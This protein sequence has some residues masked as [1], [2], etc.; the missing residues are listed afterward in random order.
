MLVEAGHCGWAGVSGR[1]GGFAS[2]SLTHGF[3]NGQE[4]WPDELGRAGPPRRREPRRHRRH[5]AT[6]RHRLPLGA[7]RRALR[8][9][10]AAPARRARGHAA[11]LA[12]A[13]PRRAAARPRT[14]CAPRSTR[15]R[16][17][18]GCGTAT[19]RRWSTRRGWPGGCGTPAS[20]LGV[21]VYE[22]TAATGRRR[23]TPAALHVRT[24][25]RATV[26][27]RPGRARHQRLP[28]AAAPAAADA[29]PVYDYVLMTEPLTAGAAGA[30]R[31]AHR[32]GLGDAAT[33]STTT[34]SPPTTGSCGA[35]T[36]RSTT[37]A[38][39]SPRARAAAGTLTGSPP[40]SSRPSRSSPG[41]RFT[42]RWAGVI[43]T[44]TRFCAVLRHGLRRTAGLRARL[45]RPRRR[46]PPAS[47]PT[48]ARPAGRRG[49]RADPARAGPRAS[50]C[51]SRRSRCA[52]PAS[53]S[54]AGRWPAPTRA[55]AGATSGCAPWTGPGSA[56]TPEPLIARRPVHHHEDCGSAERAP[57]G[58]VSM[59]FSDIEGSTLLL[60]RLG[61]RYAEAL[62]GQRGPARRHGPLT[63]AREMGTEGDSFFVVFPTAG[64]A[65]AARGRRRSA[66][67]Q[68]HAWP[69]ASGCGS[70]WAST[71]G[72]R[73]CTT[74][75]TSGWTSTAPPGSPGPPTAGRWSLSCDRRPGSRTGLPDGVA[76]QDLGSAP[77]QGPRGAGA[78]FQLSVEGLAR[79]LPAAEDPRA[80]RPACRARRP[81]WSGGTARS[82]EL[83][84]CCGHRRSGW[85]PSPDPADRARPGWRSRWP[86]AHGPHFPDGVFFVPLAAVTTAEVM[87]TLH[88]RGARRAA[89]T[90][91][92]PTG[93]SATSPTAGP[94]RA[95]QPRAAAGRRRGRRQAAGGDA[96]RDRHRDL[97]P[98]RS[99]C[100]ASTATPSRRWPCRRGDARGAERS[101]AVQLFLDQARSVGPHF[102][103]TAGERAGRGRRLRAPGRAAAG[104]R[105]VRRP[106]PAA[107]SPGAPGAPGRGPGLR[108]D[109]RAGPGPAAD[110]ARH[111]HV[112]L[113]AAR[114]GTAGVPPSG[115]RVR[116]GWRPGRRRRRHQRL[117]RSHSG[118]R[119][120]WSWSPSWSTRASPTSPRR[121]TASPASS[122][123]RPSGPSP[124]TSCGRPVRTTRPVS[125]TRG[126]TP[127]WPTGCAR[128]ASRGTCPRSPWR[129]RTWTTSGRPSPGP[130]RPTTGP[131][132]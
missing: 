4:R 50:R 43:D 81:R 34:G 51:R 8:G 103:L 101:D 48:C 59:L 60:S 80:P 77:A 98:A 73:H 83:T 131:A 22:D 127:A 87:W 122:C 7:H 69:G 96:P 111:H 112:V 45:H 62:D 118:T 27:G 114:P 38:T 126:T 46:R 109:Q 71:P 10:G 95:G 30:D 84:A 130:S 31:L 5:R 37:T 49:H 119:T 78:P 52:T 20:T 21:R 115:E 123:S 82:P 2:A 85:S 97:T 15:R 23:G 53:S 88:R 58:T 47:A 54:P 55:T 44:C 24:A 72:R 61:D 107:R 108:L 42:H 13:R 41:V 120:R 35:A 64:D 104:H 67:W 105:A 32:Q 63:A 70:A 12:A 89:A 19:A 116:R 102:R 14:R 26:P 132:R 79:G 128:C 56:S 28:A 110:P 124:A 25:A 40:T 39:G 18:A 16:T 3:A 94:A 66:G 1:N 99:H 57:S 17:S 9:H 6:A 92:R 129:R 100:A 113:R 125:G 121:T 36:T 65:V 93:C 11:E 75:A 106:D 33:S 29:V 117:R 86:T 74:T 91:A 68:R 76:L 90:N